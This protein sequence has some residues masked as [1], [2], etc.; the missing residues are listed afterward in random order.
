[1]SKIPLRRMTQNDIPLGMRLKTLAGWNQTPED[2]AYLVEKGISNWVATYESKAIGTVTTLPYS[3]ISWIGMVLVDPDYR[4]KGV[5]TQLLQQAIKHCSTPYIG[6]DA[7]QAG[8]ELYHTMG[9]VQTN[10]WTRCIRL[11]QPVPTTV[12]QIV[13]PID[14]IH[15]EAIHTYDTASLSH[16]RD[17]LL[18]Y[19]Y[20][21]SPKLAFFVKNK[22][23]IIGYG[24]GRK[25]SHYL[26]IGPILADNV[27]IAS[28]LVNQ[29]V[30]IHQD[31]QLIID[32]PDSDPKWIQ[33]LHQ[34]GFKPQRTL[35]R[36]YYQ[37][38][39]PLPPLAPF[40]Y[41]GPEFG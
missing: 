8:R 24:M 6:L 10:T 31:Q 11:P 27:A 25:G 29:A 13:Y 36:M 18:R 9:F 34:I 32:V 12:S 28:Q 7:T 37:A 16:S 17:H 33:Y 19:L 15:R 30:A 5:G 35:Y 14:P 2:W 20:E 21:N 22:G 1:M 41:A 38:V 23:E 40:A 3:I 26:H 4:R 39:P